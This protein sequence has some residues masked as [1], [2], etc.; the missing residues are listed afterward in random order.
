MQALR[1][2]FYFFVSC[3]C[4]LPASSAEVSFSKQ[5]APLLQSKCIACHGPEKAKGGFRAH[6]YQQLM[7]GGESD[8]PSIKAGDPEQSELY[9]RLI[10]EDEDERM[11]QKD[12]PFPKEQ[13]ELFKQWI[14]EGA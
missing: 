14:S 2:L 4:A 7:A 11:P 12:D 3:L 6:T 5:I 13:I 9:K 8:L 1:F 10:S